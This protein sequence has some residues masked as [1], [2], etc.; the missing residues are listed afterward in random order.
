MVRLKRLF[1]MA[2]SKGP[3]SQYCTHIATVA[4]L[5]SPPHILVPVVTSLV[6]AGQRLGGNLTSMMPDQA[7]SVDKHAALSLGIAIRLSQGAPR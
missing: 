7:I 2:W 5:P 3:P 6:V 1:L 4:E